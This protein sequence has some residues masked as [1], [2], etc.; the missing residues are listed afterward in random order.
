MGKSLICVNHTSNDFF[1]QFSNCYM[2]EN[3]DEFVMQTRSA[4]AADPSPLSDD[5][6]CKLSWEAPT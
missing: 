2:Y 4:L 5:Q 3:E 1:K 6:V